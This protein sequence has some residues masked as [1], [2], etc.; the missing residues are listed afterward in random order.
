MDLIHFVGSAKNICFL[1]IN[2]F[3]ISS[4]T[5]ELRFGHDLCDEEK[6]FLTKRK[7]EIFR[8]MSKVLRGNEMPDGVNEV[9]D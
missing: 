1:I 8:K 3:T 7:E 6:H 4:E 2:Y 5:M 9:N